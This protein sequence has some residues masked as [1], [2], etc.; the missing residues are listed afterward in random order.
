MLNRS[1]VLLA[2]AAGILGAP[3]AARAQ[4]TINLSL[5]YFTLRGEDAR[6]SSD[7]NRATR[8]ECDVLTQNS[9]FLTFDVSDV[10]GPTIG[11]EWLVPIGR[12]LEAGAGI[13][14]SR[15]TAETSYREFVDST[16]AAIEQRLRLRI[17]PIAFTFRVLPLGQ[18]SA[19]Q[20]YFG[21][22]LG[23]FNWRYSETGD[24]IDFS[25]PGRPVAPGTFVASGNE[26]GPIAVAGLRLAGD[27]LSVGGE[28][29]YQSALG[30]LSDE[31]AGRQIDLGGWTYQLTVGMRFGR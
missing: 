8:V 20:P 18:D 26:T 25:R 11:G 4:Q 12:Y 16:G 2:A 1:I 22:G 10:N 9:E 19:V 17:V 13:S 23:V 31:F 3:Q 14:L 27:T 30:E 15:R 29:R 6:Q 7:C 5:G 24:F 28:L 21:G